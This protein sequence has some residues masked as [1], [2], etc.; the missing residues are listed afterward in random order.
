MSLNVNALLRFL[1][2][3]LVA[4]DRYG[5]SYH[6][7]PESGTDGPHS[8]AQKSG[9]GQISVA[10]SGHGD[11]GPPVGVQHRHETRVSLVILKDVDQRGEYEDSHEEEE[12]QHPQ[13]SVAV[14]DWS[15]K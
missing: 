6:E 4:N 15:D 13:L 8:S 3:E 5:Q 7:N 14:P 11:Q 1:L 12:E 9:W 2:C 10:H